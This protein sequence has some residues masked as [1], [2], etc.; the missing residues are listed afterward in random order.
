MHRSQ[1]INEIN[2]EKLH[3]L[4][5]RRISS[6]IPKLNLKRLLDLLFSTNM[7]LLHMLMR[8]ERVSVWQSLST[9]KSLPTRI[10]HHVSKQVD[11]ARILS[12]IP[13]RRASSFISP[14]T[15]NEIG[16]TELS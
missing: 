2:R 3:N 12:S 11:R 15:K 16:S 8:T 9:G 14:S 7:S 10:S 6:R 5:R 13:L 1:A 4:S